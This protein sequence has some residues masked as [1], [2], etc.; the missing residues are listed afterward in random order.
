MSDMSP[1][2]P[3]DA[4]AGHSKAARAVARPTAAKRNGWVRAV[5][6]LVP[7]IWISDVER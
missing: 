3:S 6:A 4:A 7:E 2:A 5:V 1:A